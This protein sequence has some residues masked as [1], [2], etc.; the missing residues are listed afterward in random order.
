MCADIYPDNE[1]SIKMQ[2]GVTFMDENS[3]KF[4]ELDS[5]GI[6]AECLMETSSGWYGSPLPNYPSGKPVISIYKYVFPP[7]R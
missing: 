1:V 6:T 7:L 4:A 3:S 2:K 5:S